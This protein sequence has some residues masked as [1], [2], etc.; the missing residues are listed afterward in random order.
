[1]QINGLCLV[2]FGL[3][4]LLDPAKRYLLDIVD[5]SEDE[6]LLRFATY[7]LLASGALT[8]L[9]AFVGCCGAVKAGRF[10]IASVR[11]T[12]KQNTIVTFQMTFQYIILMLGLLLAAAALVALP[13]VFKQKVCFYDCKLRAINFV[14][15]PSLRIIECQFTSQIS[16]KI[17]TLV[18]VGQRRLWTQFSFMFV[19]KK[20]FAK[21]NIAHAFS[22]NVAAVKT[23]L[24]IMRIRFGI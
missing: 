15:S 6:P 21:K 22:S 20:C 4:F 9:V 14:F 16:R 13:I 2:A 12:N 8:L 19:S 7:T 1:M 18:I 17:A 10:V 3:W 23:A 5:F 24:V 11:A